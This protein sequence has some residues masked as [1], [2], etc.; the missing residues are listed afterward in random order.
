MSLLMFL[1]KA[2]S[3]PIVEYR[4]LLTKL[5][6]HEM[7]VACFLAVLNVLSSCENREKSAASQQENLPYI[8][9][10]KKLLS[11]FS[12]SQTRSG[13]WIHSWFSRSNT[14]DSPSPPWIHYTPCVI[15]PLLVLLY[16]SLIPLSLSHTHTFSLAVPLRLTLVFHCRFEQN[17]LNEIDELCKFCL[18]KTVVVVSFVPL[19]Y[20][21][22]LLISF[23]LL[24]S[25]F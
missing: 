19:L 23:Q 15:C 3:S 14:K 7:C 4:R 1:R 6:V 17:F 20:F 10:R 8:C 24:F 16:S 21:P 2:S 25:S 9:T 12:H 5:M 18:K 22:H 13:P 11:W